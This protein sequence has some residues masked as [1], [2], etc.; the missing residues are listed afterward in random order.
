MDKHLIGNLLNWLVN[1]KN[2]R[3]STVERIIRDT[4]RLLRTVKPLNFDTF[5]KDITNLKLKGYKSNY[6]ESVV[7]TAR[8]FTQF[9]KFCNKPYDKR[10]LKYPFPKPEPTYKGILTD[11]EIEAIINYERSGNESKFVHAIWSL[12][13]EILSYTGMRPGELAT[14]KTENI[15]LGRRVFIIEARYCKT[16]KQRLVPI[17]SNI[18][19]KII[20][21][22]RSKKPSDYL[23]CFRSG[24]IFRDGD[25]WYHFNKRIT[26]LGLKRKGISV[27]S[28]RHSFATSL[29]SENMN[30]FQVMKCLGHSDPKTTLVYSH[31]TTKDLHNTIQKLPLLRDKLPPSETVKIIKELL[32]SFNLSN[33]FEYK[34]EEKKNGLDFSIRYSS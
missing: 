23:L 27:Y 9:L 33:R 32:M 16:N 1:I 15:D 7:V 29:L 20:P 4:K 22:I 5:D 24:K 34:L 10:L 18:I 19:D 31:L 6:I 3:S 28:L 25:W 11:K 2:N 17:P 8:I 30:L 12:F 21:I 13:F 26:K 14:L